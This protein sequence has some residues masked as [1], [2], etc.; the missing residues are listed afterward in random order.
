MLIKLIGIKFDVYQSLLEINLKCDFIDKLT[1]LMFQLFV[2]TL[3]IFS[4]DDDIYIFMT[5]IY[6]RYTFA[7]Y[8][9][10]K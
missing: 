2:F 9:I 10:C 7:M 1:Y 3:C 5:S 6:T 4:Y 8:Y